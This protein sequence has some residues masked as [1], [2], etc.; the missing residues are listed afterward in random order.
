MTATF[1]LELQT[2]WTM[3]LHLPENGHACPHMYGEKQLPADYNFFHW[4]TRRWHVW[5]T[6]LFVCSAATWGE[7][8]ITFRI[9]AVS[10]DNEVILLWERRYSVERL[11]GRAYPLWDD[12]LGRDLTSAKG[13]THRSA[14]RMRPVN[15]NA[16]EGSFLITVQSR[17]R[18][19]ALFSE[20][21][22]CKPWLTSPLFQHFS[23]KS[24]QSDVWRQS[25]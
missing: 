16:K 1:L 17:Q 24:D 18:D 25:Q 10:V 5:K 19:T 12:H 11:R 23:R 21:T 14:A 6:A 22:S 8:L 20:N 13:I 4:G 9:S 7:I 15:H 3:G 2:I